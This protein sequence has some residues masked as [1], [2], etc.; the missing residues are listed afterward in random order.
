M[1]PTDDFKKKNLRATL[2]YTYMIYDMIIIWYDR[3]D[4][5]WY[6]MI[7]Y[8]MIWYDMIWYDT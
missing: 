6:D 5:I 8:D 4:M 3:Y 2:I 7:W 1:V